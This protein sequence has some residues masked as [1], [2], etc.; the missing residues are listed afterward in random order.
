MPDAKLRTSAATTASVDMSRW[1]STDMVAGGATLVLFVSLFLPWFE[2]GGQTTNGLWHGF[3]YITLIVSLVLVVYLVMRACVPTLAL[4]PAVPHDVL[5]AAGTGINFALVLVGF[6]T[7]PS[8]FVLVITIVANWDFG[9]FLALLAASVAAAA[10]FGP[11]LRDFVS[12][13]M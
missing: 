11:R 2:Y 8:A 9:A 3:E 13:G 10:V 7:R 12:Q 1:S 6:L 4:N 5:L